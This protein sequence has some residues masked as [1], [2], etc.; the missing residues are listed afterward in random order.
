[1]QEGQAETSGVEVNTLGKRHKQKLVLEIFV[2]LV[3]FLLFHFL[4]AGCVKNCS[5]NAE[6]KR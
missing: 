5:L 3:P 2:G 6:L 1:M 4:V